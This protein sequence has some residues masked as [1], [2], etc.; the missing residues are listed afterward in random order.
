MKI[1]E[2]ITPVE[3][4]LFEVW[5][6][7]LSWGGAGDA[8]AVAKQTKANAAALQAAKDA[9][10]KFKDASPAVQKIL[11]NI[12]ANATAE[13][14]AASRVALSAKLGTMMHLLTLLGA[15]AITIEL[16]FNWDA[17][18]K[19]YNAGDLN[20]AQYK[21]AHEAYFGLWVIQFMVPWLAR[22]LGI[23]KILTFLV[24]VIVGVLTLGSSALTGGA[25]FF[26][27]IAGL[28]IEQ[29]IFTGIQAFM[30]TKTFET[31]MA[32]HFFATLVTIGTIPD[33]S[34]N[35]LRGYLTKI[36]GVDK[37]VKNPGDDFY[38]SQDKNRPDDVRARDTSDDVHRFKDDNSIVINGVVVAD[39][40]G[41]IDDYALMGPFVK[42]YIDLHP[43]DPAVQKL[44]ALQKK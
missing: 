11:A 5:Y 1:Y 9:A 31:W 18:E 6:N 10:G 15:V 26:A 16:Y 37:L 2:V 39:G 34:W 32:Q 36:P 17:I 14:K 21:E 12:S 19:Q 30:M 23:A 35:I 13:A 8:G 24:R 4:N 44:K 41:N 40:K 27:S 7:P 3:E 43:Q 25:T 42:N 20:K 38:T 33:E 28:A 22:V 29:A